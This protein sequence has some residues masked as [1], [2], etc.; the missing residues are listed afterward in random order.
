M[1]TGAVCAQ[2]RLTPEAAERLLIEKPDPV[3]PPLAKQAKTQGTLKVDITVSEAGAVAADGASAP[4]YEYDA[5]GNLTSVTQGTQTR[6][7]HYDSL[8]RLKDATNPESGL[9]SYTYYDSGN[10]KTRTDARYITTT[11]TY[12]TEN[13]LT[14]KSYS[15]GTPTVTYTWDT[16][17]NCLKK[18]LCGVQS[19]SSSYA[20]NYQYNLLGQT[21]AVTQTTAGTPYLSSYIYDLQG[22]VKQITYPSTRVVGYTLGSAGRATAAGVPAVAGAYASSITYAPHGALSGMAMGNGVVET[23]TFDPRLRAGTI[24]AAKSNSQLLAI[25][26]GYAANGNVST[27]TITL[28]SSPYYTQTFGY[29]S[30]N[31]LYSAWEQNSGSGTNLWSQYY[32]YDQYGNRALSSSFTGPLDAAT[33][34][35]QYMTNQSTGATA[36]RYVYASDN[37]LMPSD[38]YDG[39]GNLQHHPKTG[40]FA[41]DAENRM[42]SATPTGL[43]TTTY[44]YDGEGRRVSSVTAGGQTTI[45]V[46]GADGQ[47]LAEYGNT[48]SA[49][50]RYLTVDALGS[51]RLVTDAAGTVASRHD[52]APFGEELPTVSN[53]SVRTA[54]NNFIGQEPGVRQA[55]TGKERDAETA[56]D[57]FGA[58]YFSGAQGRFTSPDQPFIDQDASNPQSWNLYNYGRNNPLR[59]RDP[60]GRKCVQTS[61]GQA[62]DGTGGGCEAAGVDSQGNIS[63]YTVSAIDVSQRGTDLF[64][65]GRL[66]GEGGIEHDYAADIGFLGLLRGTFGRLLGGAAAETAG[67]ALFD[68]APIARGNAIEQALG[69]NLPRTFPTFDKFINGVAT[70]IKSID[71]RAVSYQNPGNVE[72][73]LTNYVDKVADFTSG[74]VGRTAIEGSQISGRVLEVAVPQ[75]GVSAAQQA[76][77]SRVTAAAAQRGVQV[78]VIPIR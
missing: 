38:A 76:V 21:T 24:T 59:Y 13:R 67:P 42:T 17:T 4:A 5:L 63:S 8:S 19:G 12:D 46:Y 6:T 50:T 53:S 11:F 32:N 29:D 70:S 64:V 33:S 62:D 14:G 61:N 75:G 49:R 2:T 18:F 52:Y 58:K 3:Y 51:T 39:A 28:N 56:L 1:G 23:V 74:A 43:P 45:F 57:Y 7:S 22:N 34:T 60:T 65:N 37:S 73:L 68:L 36:N 78:V 72:R 31:R 25:T 71:L 41:F 20:T 26:N 16:G 77:L 69:A 55:F 54:A 27:Q 47:L 66:V 15:D 10:L 30:A 35:L 40:Q 48:S 9:T 44:T